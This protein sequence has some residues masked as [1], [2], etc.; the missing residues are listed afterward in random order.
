M[1]EPGGRKRGLS[2][3]ETLE[4]S[5]KVKNKNPEN[6]KTKS[7]HGTPVD[8]AVG[9][10]VSEEDH[11]ELG[12]SDMEATATNQPKPGET[13]TPPQSKTTQNTQNISA[14]IDLSYPNPE[15]IPNHVTKLYLTSTTHVNS[16]EHL[17]LT[18]ICKDPRLL[19]QS[20]N[21]LAGPVDSLQYLPAG[22]L[23]VYCKTNQQLKN[24]ITKNEIKIGNKTIP[25]KFSLA[26]KSQTTMGKI[27]A[28]NLTDLSL[29]EIL[30]ELKDQNV[31]AVEK[32]LK[33]PSKQDQPL[34]LITFIG[35][36]LPSKVYVAF[37]P[38]RVDPYKPNP[39]RCTN[40]LLF[41]HSK[42]ICTNKTPRCQKC[43]E[44]GHTLGECQA[45]FTKCFH[46]KGE[47]EAFDKNCPKL[48]EEK[49]IHYIRISQNM[50]YPDAKQ[51]YLIQNTQENP[52]SYTVIPSAMTRNAQLTPSSLPNIEVQNNPTI[53]NTLN[54]LTNNPDD[55]YLE[56][57]NLGIIPV[58][59]GHQATQNTPYSQAVRTKV[60]NYHN[61]LIPKNTT[62]QYKA[63]IP[64]NPHNSQI[65]QNTQNPP[66]LQ[67]NGNS[68]NLRPTNTNHNITQ[69]LTKEVL[70]SL[71]P[72]ILKIFFSD[73]LTTK[74]EC[75]KEIG[76]LLN[77]DET[78]DK[79]LEEL[80]V[81]SLS[82]TQ[83]L[84]Q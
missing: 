21:N 73:A 36:T 47:H 13:S 2:P 24:L 10:V 5:K 75:I 68:Q 83:S 77:I 52:R 81:S 41:R 64:Q 49:E 28:P 51:A 72:L 84:S 70:A 59:A 8:G 33:D 27:Y 7:N 16:G 67:N 71:V 37:C 55:L 58:I 78:I 20:I 44:K 57:T 38:F 61:P 40:C 31:I 9:G 6:P 48:I 65:F 76:N 14:S 18:K 43:G 30:E 34:Y 11:S 39:H 50:E 60:K 82:I 29:G 42:K 69:N 53:G 79:T 46:C 12:V 32:L 4:D 66:A 15:D 54:L 45:D 26:L 74:V 56:D 1:K 3:T 19:L 62:Y 23:F 17:P 63:I 22:S 25:V 80:N 35:T